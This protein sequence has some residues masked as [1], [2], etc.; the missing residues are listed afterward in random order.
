M[1]VAR[2]RRV[3]VAVVLAVVACVFAALAPASP[4]GS[5][6]AADGAGAVASADVAHFAV[7]SPAMI[8]AELIAT[9][10][11]GVSP[12]N[13]VVAVSWAPLDP[14]IN[15]SSTWWN[16]VAAYGNAAANTQCAITFNQNQAFDW[17]MFCTVMVH[18]IGHLVGQQHSTDATSVMYP[19][20]VAPVAA[21]QGTPAA[22]AGF[23]AATV[24][25]RVVKHHKAPR[26]H[27][28]A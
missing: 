9:K 11:W 20:Y 3:V 13:G 28:A 25:S 5:H 27:R 7:G 14:A 8:Q 15:G 22:A 16:P 23:R 19:I 12:C 26:R 1:P 2:L 10:Y 6:R 17:P 24:K 18:E 21:C 4:A